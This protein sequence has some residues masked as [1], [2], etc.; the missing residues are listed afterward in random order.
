MSGDWDTDEGLAADLTAALRERAEVPEQLVRIGKDAFAW[1]TVDAELAELTTDEP[2]LAGSRAEGAALRTLTFVASQVTIEVE[3]TDTALVGQIVPPQP[4]ELTLRGRDG[5]TRVVPVDAVG[6]FQLRPRPAGR[7][8]L[9]LRAVS[10]LSVLTE[11][12]SL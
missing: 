8:Q 1:H 5:S 12:T 7:F 9:H 6:W 11:W 4:G 3:V 2:E 10:G